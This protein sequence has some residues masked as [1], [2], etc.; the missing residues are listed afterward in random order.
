MKTIYKILLFLLIILNINTLTVSAKNW[1]IE[2]ITNIWVDTI[3]KYKDNYV[4]YIKSND[5]YKRDLLNPTTEIQLTQWLSLWCVWTTIGSYYYDNMDWDNFYYCY[6]NKFYRTNIADWNLTDTSIIPWTYTEIWTIIKIMNW[7]IYYINGWSA[8]K[9][10]EI[11]AITAPTLQSNLSTSTTYLWY[12]DWY[13][14]WRRYQ[15]WTQSYVYYKTNWNYPTETSYQLTDTTDPYWYRSY[16]FSYKDWFIYK[17]WSTWNPTTKKNV[18]FD[19]LSW[20]MNGSIV[21]D[22]LPT[23]SSYPNWYYET[24]LQTFNDWYIYTDRDT[25]YIFYKKYTDIWTW[26][27]GIFLFD[28]IDAPY[29]W[30]ASTYY[31]NR[32]YI[33]WD[34]I[35]FIWKYDF[36]LKKIYIGNDFYTSI[37]NDS[38][39]WY[40]LYSNDTFWI[41]SQVNYW[42]N[43]VIDWNNVYHQMWGKIYKNNVFLWI[44]VWYGTNYQSYS[45]E[46]R[47]Q[48][49][50]NFV[51]DN[52]YIYY[53]ATDWNVYKTTTEWWVWTVFID[54][55]KV[56][57]SSVWKIVNGNLLLWVWDS[58]SYP[59][60]WT[61]SSKSLLDT[62]PLWNLTTVS[63]NDLSYIIN[64]TSTTYWYWFIPI[65]YVYE[66]WYLYKISNE[67][68]K[69]KCSTTETVWV[70]YKVNYGSIV[71]WYLWLDRYQWITDFKVK[72]DNIVIK[73]TKW[74]S[75]KTYDELYLMSSKTINQPKLFLRTD[76]LYWVAGDESIGWF[77]LTD[78]NLY[79]FNVWNWW[80]SN[81]YKKALDS[82]D[83]NILWESLIEWYSSKV[84]I[85]TLNATIISKLYISEDWLKLYFIEPTRWLL[86]SKNI[87]DYEKTP[88]TMSWNYI[89]KSNLENILNYSNTINNNTNILWKPVYA[90]KKTTT[91]LLSDSVMKSIIDGYFNNT[92]SYNDKY[93]IL[94]QNNIYTIVR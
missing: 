5:L 87:T 39:K 44:N 9:R 50:S 53:R 35:Y 74:A 70:C 80:R 51:L 14:I 68:D 78:K 60:Y 15:A 64:Y 4:F 30:N 63:T 94:K 29:S 67:N 22:T 23:I 82:T 21:S 31:S 54:K 12:F 16:L 28:D 83:T 72:W 34:Y 93:M 75:T 86:I 88:I 3:Y 11:S 10:K 91:S 37:S 1:D 57:T 19:Y 79:Y 18:N 56:L 6:N 47:D 52:W 38:L 89:Y 62:N 20:D 58:S 49:F 2:N 65:R 33:Y 32:F 26:K 73:V 92:T 90:S 69:T 17:G 36:Y 84:N 45:L 81:L 59:W 85:N 71:L 46:S 42:K 13:F 61:V 55:T 41:T 66:N 40:Y 76:R 48:W 25:W 43:V 24:I 8:L 7:Y 77:E 27:L